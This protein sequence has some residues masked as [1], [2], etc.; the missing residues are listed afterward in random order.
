MNV[1][2]FILLLMSTLNY[3]AIIFAHLFFFNYLLGSIVFLLILMWL[4]YVLG[5]QARLTWVHL[6]YLA[7]NYPLLQGVLTIQVISLAGLPPMAG[8]F[9]KYYSFT[10]LVQTGY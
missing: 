8:F 6:R 5:P 7:K 4:Q 3:R 9:F 1:L 10:A 2:G